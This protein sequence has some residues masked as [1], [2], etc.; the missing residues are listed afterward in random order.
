MLKNSAPFSTETDDGLPSL[1]KCRIAASR[2]LEEMTKDS[3]VFR[4]TKASDP[5]DYARCFYVF[6][7]HTLKQS[8]SLPHERLAADIR[9]AVRK[10]RQFSGDC[11]RHKLFR[12]LLTFSLSALKLLDGLREDA[13][14]DLV[15]EQLLCS[16]N[17]ELEQFGCLDGRAGSG[18]QA[19]FMAIFLIHARDYLGMG[20]Q[21]LLDEWGEAHTK[22][23]NRFGFWGA[24]AGMTHLQFQNGYHQHEILEYL[25]LEN[26]RLEHT[27]AAVRGLV[28]S[29]GHFAPYPGGGGCY[30]YDAVFMLTPE[31]R[32]PD[33]AA[34]ALLLR[35][36]A[37]IASEQRPDGGFAESVRVRPRS[38]TNLRRFASHTLD[39][40]GKGPLFTERLRYGLTLQR[41]KHDRI[42]T[43]WSQYSRRWD[44][45][46]L[47]DTWFRMLTLARI[48]VAMHPDH[49][50][51]WGFIDYPGIG[52][53]PSLRINNT[54]L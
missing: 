47:W 24:D 5:S 36:A 9:K 28:D 40:L 19:M 29:E 30:D 45:S 3:G 10:Q 37:T 27:L 41:P 22:Q 7:A 21:P 25:G 12:Q 50:S 23:M 49:A 31:G 18:N 43:H 1:K 15:E 44:E 16:L 46:D 34:R 13:L 32:V 4:L 53:H 17:D 14:E 48:D 20:T 51:N 2:Y 42:H 38:I 11:F 6:L 35:T 33:E 8:Q 39:A 26:P 54:A 52:Y